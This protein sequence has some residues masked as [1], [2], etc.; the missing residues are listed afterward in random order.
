[1]TAIPHHHNHTV[2]QTTRWHAIDRLVLLLAVCCFALL[3]FGA[4]QFS[5][6]NSENLE[7]DSVIKRISDQPFMSGFGVRRGKID[8]SST[9]VNEDIAQTTTINPRRV[10]I[11]LQ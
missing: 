10:V 1:M 4:H 7:S 9:S 8:T 11:E 6:N 5:P 2:R 3:V